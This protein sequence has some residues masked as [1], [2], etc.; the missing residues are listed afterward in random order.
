VVQ[1][2][3]LILGQSL[4]GVIII[5]ELIKK[6]SYAWPYLLYLIFPIWYF[7]LGAVQNYPGE[8]YTVHSFI[9]DYI[10]LLPIFILPYGIWFP[11]FL[12]TLLFAITRG[13][14]FFWRSTLFLFGG[15]AVCSL[16]HTVFPTEFNRPDAIPVSNI[17]DY[18]LVFTYDTDV[19]TRVFPSIHC[20]NAMVAFV[21]MCKAGQ[22][23]WRKIIVPLWGVIAV[24]ICL[25]TVFI[26]QHSILDWPGAIAVMVVMYP[27]AYRVNYNF[28]LNFRRK[29]SNLKSKKLAKTPEPE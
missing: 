12:G 19:P 9:D 28:L 8:F 4:R 13:K 27:L 1:S 20:Y 5:K 10:P 18:A 15:I 6:Y 29:K 7:L 26:K 3:R 24:L 2:V 25:A 21:I 11:F 16:I 17:I 22:F 23:K 14:E